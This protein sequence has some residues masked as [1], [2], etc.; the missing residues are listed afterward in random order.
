MLQARGP[1]PIDT[2]ERI[3][4]LR[5]A[6]HEADA[7]VRSVQCQTSR[8]RALACLPP[9]RLE[10]LWRALIAD[11][12]RVARVY[13]HHLVE[14]IEVRCDDVVVVP[15]NMADVSAMRV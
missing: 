11:D 7:H 15:M 6:L 9:E 4:T 10:E 12:H 2:A 8:M 13:L 14:R 1:V 3:G 5:G